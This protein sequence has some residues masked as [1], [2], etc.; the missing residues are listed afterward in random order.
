MNALLE[1]IIRSPEFPKLI[2]QLQQIWSE[3]QQRRAKFREELTPEMKAEFIEGQ[4]VMHSPARNIHLNATANLGTLLRFYAEAKQLGMVAFE[5][6]LICLTRNDFEPDIVFFHKHRSASFTP[7]QMEFPAP[8]LAVEILSDSTA[9]RDRTLKLND[10]AAHGVEEYWIIDADERFVEQ[11]VLPAESATYE[12]HAKLHAGDHLRSKV[13]P[14]FTIP[15]EAIFDGS[16][17]MKVLR[18]LLG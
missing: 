15:I 1:P 18:E 2:D 8:D 14:G 17:Q 16:E 13:L 11:Y 12:L 6:A 9:K 3:E 4:V 10:Y 7:H 5:K